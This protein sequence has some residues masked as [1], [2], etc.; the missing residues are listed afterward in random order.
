MAGLGKENGEMGKMGFI[1][2]KQIKPWN[3]PKTQKERMVRIAT[4]EVLTIFL[5]HF[6]V[7]KS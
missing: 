2:D 1:K 5:G 4:C 7:R 6:H 3:K